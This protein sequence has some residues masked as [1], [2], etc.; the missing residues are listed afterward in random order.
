MEWPCWEQPSGGG[1][2]HGKVPS[3]FPVSWGLAA[4]SPG[5]VV[6]W[7]GEAE[8]SCPLDAPA[9]KAPTE[10]GASGL[11]EWSWGAGTGRGARGHL[12]CILTAPEAWR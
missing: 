6:P 9:C 5:C 4:G 1:V 11:A 3:L 10:H 12:T 8:V 2:S 7:R